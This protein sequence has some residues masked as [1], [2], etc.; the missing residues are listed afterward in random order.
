MPPQHMLAPKDSLEMVPNLD[1]AL[2]K[3][4]RLITLPKFYGIHIKVNKVFHPSSQ[5][6]TSIP[7]MKVQD[8]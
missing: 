2:A 5:M 6:G 7:N 8:N 1:E 3:G 4:H